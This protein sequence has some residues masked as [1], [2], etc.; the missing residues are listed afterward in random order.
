V[1]SSRRTA[2]PEVVVGA[3]VALLGLVLWL[4]GVVGPLREAD[5][6]TRVTGD[7][8]RPGWKTLKRDG[9]RV[10][11]PE[12]WRRLPTDGCRA[13]E[14]ET[15]GPA[16]ATSCSDEGV[17]FPE[18]TTFDPRHEDGVVAAGIGAADPAWSGYVHTG[19]V[20]VSV[21]G[22]DR[23]LVRDVLD[24]VDLVDGGFQPIG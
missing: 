21:S 7:A 5:A 13:G 12:G 4:G 24:S 9:V 22:E 10:D 18:P 17:S 1:T 3:V 19:D 6:G 14:D 15:W 20:V 8:A 23:D 11:V 16:G 2:R